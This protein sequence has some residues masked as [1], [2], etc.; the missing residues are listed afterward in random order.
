MKPSMLYEALHALIGE[1]VVK[2][3]RHAVIENAEQSDQRDVGR[4]ELRDR[5]KQ[6]R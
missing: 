6:D 3:G 4:I 1:R 2:A 5:A